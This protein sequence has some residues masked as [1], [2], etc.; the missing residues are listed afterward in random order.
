MNGSEESRLKA[1]KALNDDNPDSVDVLEDGLEVYSNDK[2]VP[3]ASPQ[4]QPPPP[5]SSSSSFAEYYRQRSSSPPPLVISARDET[6]GDG[7]SHVIPPKRQ[8]IT[9]SSSAWGGV[10]EKN[11]KNGSSVS[12]DAALVMHAAPTSYTVQTSN[13]QG[14]AGGNPVGSA[15][16]KAATQYLN[17]ECLYFSLRSVLEKLFSFWEREREQNTRARERERQAH[18]SCICVG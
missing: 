4:K 3:V 13:Q 10:A 11:N 12:V 7:S 17:G 14:Y 9:D 6:A 15:M 1:P 5:L 18:Y 8:R 2:H 16:H